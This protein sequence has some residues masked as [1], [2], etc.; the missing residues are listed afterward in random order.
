MGRLLTTEVFCKL[1]RGRPPGRPAKFYISHLA[2]RGGYYPPVSFRVSEAT[3]NLI[4]T[5]PEFCHS[6]HRRC[7]E[8]LLLYKHKLFL[9]CAGVTFGAKSNQ[10]VGDGVDRR[11]WRMKGDGERENN[12]QTRGASARRS[13]RRLFF[14]A[15]YGCDSP[16]PLN[17]EYVPYCLTNSSAT[18]HIRSQ[19][20]RVLCVCRHIHILY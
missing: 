13:M 20:A 15:I 3:R 16:A 19:R 8:S 4:T 9:R 6:E 1:G 18:A 12:E 10:N 11:Q 14:R 5:K 2:R 17:A 7:E